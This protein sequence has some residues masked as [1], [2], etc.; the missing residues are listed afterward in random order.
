MAENERDVLLRRYAAG[1][2]TWSYLRERGWDNYLDVLTGL[3][4]RGL[5]L[6]IAPMEGPLCEARK[7]GRAYIREA[8]QAAR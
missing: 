1:E 3:G 4:D 6:P 2:I 7:R 5:R 8:L